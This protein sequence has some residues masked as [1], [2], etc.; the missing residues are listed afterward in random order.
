MVSIT[1]NCHSIAAMF[2][3]F[4]ISPKT[5]NFTF[6]FVGGKGLSSIGHFIYKGIPKQIFTKDIKI[7]CI[8]NANEGQC[9][10]YIQ[11]FSKLK[12]NDQRN[13]QKRKSKWK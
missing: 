13:E 5:C 12:K 1:V 11:I 3:G 2:Y 10:K 8:N 6:L 4:L 9:A 7:K